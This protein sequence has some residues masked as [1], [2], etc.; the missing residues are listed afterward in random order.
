MRLN[1]RYKGTKKSVWQNFQ[2][3]PR[4]TA[5]CPEKKGLLMDGIVF[6]VS[7]HPNYQNITRMNLRDIKIDYKEL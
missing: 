1:F 2:S 3:P 7:L 5:A 6:F 4:A